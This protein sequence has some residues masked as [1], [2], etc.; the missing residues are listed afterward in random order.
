MKS[1]ACLLLL[2]VTHLVTAKDL[3]KSSEAV[4]STA[5]ANTERSAIVVQIDEQ[6]L[7]N[8]SQQFD[9]QLPNGINTTVVFDRLESHA[10]NRFSWFGHLK[11]QPQEQL[12]ITAVNGFYA[13]SLYTKAGVFE[14]TSAQKNHMRIAELATENFPD[15]D[16]EV[17]TDHPI[18]EEN[19]IQNIPQSN[20]GGTVDFD[21]MVLYT[22]QARDAAGGVAAIEA[23][24]QAAV[25]AM[26]LSF[27]NSNVDA[28]GNLSYTGLVNY[29]DTGDI[30]D[31]LTWVRNDSN[32]AELR[33]AYG[34]DMISLLVNTGGCGIGYVMRHPGT[35]FAE[36][37][38]QVTR[39]NCAVGNLTFAHEFGHNMGLEH[40]PE[41][42][43]VTPEGASNPWSFGHYHSG[44]Y[45]TVMS[46]SAQCT[47]GCSRRQYF[48]NPNVQ[49]NSLD[50]GIEGLRDNARTLIQTT[51][52]IA[53]FRAPAND[54]LFE[55]SFE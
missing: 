21:L 52:I 44:S 32:V 31:D 26:N 28:Q 53:D 35:G 5:L 9:I 43:S 8:R 14:F 41:D 7:L 24:A 3:F 50:T 51:A 39:R 19:K 54:T 33:T 48:S 38:F 30:S 17:E 37:A 18:I 45:R 22:P 34:A 20:Q 55:D 6:L 40:N 27:I 13:G 47:G 25:D 49:F 1:M 12:F 36:F 2:S 46:Y 42:S 10:K 11:G 15:C 16:G 4:N 23:T 29:N